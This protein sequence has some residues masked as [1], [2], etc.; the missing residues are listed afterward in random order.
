M[1]VPLTPE[2]PHFSVTQVAALP[3]ARYPRTPHR[4]ANWSSGCPE[5]SPRT[6]RKLRS[7]I[8]GWRLFRIGDRQGSDV[9]AKKIR[10]FLTI[11][12]AALTS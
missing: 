8:T 10:N 4:G 3:P 11:F 12:T 6:V 9:E 7:E 1:S 2:G 5:R